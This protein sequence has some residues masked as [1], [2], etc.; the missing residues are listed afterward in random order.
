MGA[1]LSALNSTLIN[2]ETVLFVIDHFKTVLTVL[3]FG[4]STSKG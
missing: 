2:L 4:D 1:E 3:T